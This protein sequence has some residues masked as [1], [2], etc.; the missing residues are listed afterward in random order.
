[1]KR[2][3]PTVVQIVPITTLDKP[4]FP[5]KQNTQD[6]DPERIR[7]LGTSPQQGKPQQFRCTGDAFRQVCGRNDKGE[8]VKA[9]M[10]LSSEPTRFLMCHDAAEQIIRIDTFPDIENGRLER[11][12]ETKVV[13]VRVM[14]DKAGTL[15]VEDYP[16]RVPQTSI[17]SLLRDLSKLDEIQAGSTIGQFE[18]TAE[19]GNLLE[20]TYKGGV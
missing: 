5:F 2:N 20:L 16:K 17:V 1:M 3:N 4:K 14:S 11:S 10:W 13:K 6:I 19:Q 12:K 18:V 7:L 9:P 8:A 15:H